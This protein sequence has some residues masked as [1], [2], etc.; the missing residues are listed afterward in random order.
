[1]RTYCIAQG[2]LLSALWWPKWEGNPKK[3]GYIYI[4][5]GWFTLLY[6][7]NWHSSVKQLY[8]NK[9]K[10]LKKL[11]LCWYLSYLV[12]ISMSPINLFLAHLSSVF[13]TNLLG[14]LW[15]LDHRIALFPLYMLF[16]GNVELLPTV[17]G[18]L[19]SIWK[20]LVYFH[21]W[22]YNRKW[23]P[24][25]RHSKAIKEARLVER[26]VC[27]ILDVNNRGGGVGEGRLLSK[28]WPPA[29]DNQ[30]TRDFIDRERGLHAE[31]QSA[32]TVILKLV[33]QWSS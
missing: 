17:R 5:M 2:T 19:S 6:S 16:L 14:Y 20:M 32:L 9:K 26:K 25:A 23:G 22:Y 12:S 3:R 30:G 11:V 21:L 15:L 31:K 18:W 1:M 28:G 10:N 33:M 7:R 13:S 8:S 24:A 29:P 27:F 4:P